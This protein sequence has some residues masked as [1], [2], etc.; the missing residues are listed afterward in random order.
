[1]LVKCGE[2]RL[3]G[4][5]ESCLVV[6]RALPNGVS[7]EDGDRRNPTWYPVTRMMSPLTELGT[8]NTCY[9]VSYEVF[10]VF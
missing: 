7:S 8:C 4:A 3:F 1:M 2:Y 9:L 5:D 6:V 10:E